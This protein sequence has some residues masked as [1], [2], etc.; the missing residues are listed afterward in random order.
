MRS[1]RPALL[2]NVSLVHTI[3]EGECLAS[4]AYQAGFFY[5]TL[6]KLDEN[7]E[8]KKGGRA[9]HVL[10][11][12]DKIFI[13][14]KKLKQ[15]DCKTDSRHRFKRKG[16]PER[17]RVRFEEQ[18][19]PRAGVP[20][21]VT[22]DGQDIEGV[23]AGDG[24]VDQP[25]SPAAREVVIVLRPTDGPEE[26]YKLSPRALDPVS[27]VRGVQGRLRNL[28]FYF[29]PLD[30]EWNDETRNALS[31]F[32]KSAKLDPTGKCDDKTADALQS[33]HGT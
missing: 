11:P 21:V 32:Q 2:S 28:G 24:L 25:I 18:G 29:G 8:L 3:G 26:R 33:A 20:Y 19:K 13:P 15:Q 5:E 22:I 27:Q 4:V 14:D 9:P 23:T 10:S 17:L 7:A 16:I 31:A 6:W 12:G 30:G 1:G